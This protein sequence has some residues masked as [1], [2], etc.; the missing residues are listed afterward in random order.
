MFDGLF[1]NV[2]GVMCSMQS[3]T[4]IECQCFIKLRYKCGLSVYFLTIK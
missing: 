4:A 3:V 1:A 2:V